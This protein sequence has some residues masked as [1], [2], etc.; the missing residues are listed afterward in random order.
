MSHI[1]SKASQ[2]FKFLGHVEPAIVSSALN[3]RIQGIL[4]QYGNGQPGD[5][6]DPS[7]NQLTQQSDA[8]FQFESLHQP[9]E[10]VLNGVPSWA[11]EDD[12]QQSRKDSKRE[13]VRLKVLSCS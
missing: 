5:H 11:V 1:R 7:S 13:M 4:S 2:L 12:K 6:L 3:S 8:C 10:Y 9:V